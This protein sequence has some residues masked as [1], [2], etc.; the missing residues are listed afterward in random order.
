[1]NCPSCGRSMPPGAAACLSC[2]ARPIVPAPPMTRLER[3]LA[4]G[5]VA[6]A[7]LFL[8]FC[9][10]VP[11]WSNRMR[12][13]PGAACRNN[14]RQLQKAC[15]LYREKFGIDP[16]GLR[17]IYESGFR[18]PW[19]F[20]CPHGGDRPRVVDAQSWADIEPYVS[21]EYR[22]PTGQAEPKVNPGFVI[23]WDK[24]PHRN[25]ERSVVFYGEGLLV[26]VMDEAELQQALAAGP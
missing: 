4:I 8:L 2:G 1:M 24:K 12:R 17:D 26:R 19:L 11:Y 6:L 20:V 22:A 9:V 16:P 3:V 5:C 15:S 18:E 10:A 7:G 14:L 13:N 25:G 21:Y 23:A